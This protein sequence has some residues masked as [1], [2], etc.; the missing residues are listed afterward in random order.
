MKSRDK[1][2]IPATIGLSLLVITAC[3]SCGASS[4]AE[5]DAQAEQLAVPII[6]TWQ[7]GAPTASPRPT[8]TPWPTA[9][10]TPTRTPTPGPVR[11]RSTTVTPFS[12][13]TAPRGQLAATPGALTPTAT[14]T[15]AAAGQP[16]RFTGPYWVESYESAPDSGYRAYVSIDIHGGEPPFT[17]H[18]DLD[19]YRNQG[20]HVTMSTVEAGCVINHT[21][22]VESADGQT[23]SQPYRLEA[24]WC[25]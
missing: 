20:R 21:I 6:E 3:V 10:P 24:P 14:T 16:L 7:A 2:I 19:I 15:A 12:L 17:V 5:I 18:H 1:Q 9:T 11:V 22:T 8:S 4:P 13:P 23:Y 25:D